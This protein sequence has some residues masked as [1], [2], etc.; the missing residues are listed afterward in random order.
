MKISI[1]DR[2][3]IKRFLGTFFVAIMLMIAIILVFDLSEK[4]GKF[5]ENKIPAKLVIFNYYFSLVPYYLNI[6]MS[7]FI[8]ISIIFFTSKMAGRS[9][10]IAM[11]SGGISFIRI[12]R[13]YFITAGILATLSFFLGNFI[14]PPAN[15]T[16][17]EFENKYIYYHPD[18]D[19]RNIHKQVHQGIFVYIKYYDKVNDIGHIFTLEK[20]Q[21]SKLISK[22]YADN[23]FWDEEN[24]L[25]HANNY[26][27]RT[28]NKF[29]DDFT[30][31]SSIDTT[32]FLTPDDIKENSINISTLNLIE[33]NDFID[34]QRLHGNENI[35]DF[36][37]EKHKRLALPFSAF[38]LAFIGVSMSARKKRGGTGIYLGIGITLSFAYILLSKLSDQWALNG[39]LT[40]FLAVWMPNFI[41]VFVSFLLYRFAPK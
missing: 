2:Y 5:M 41:F 18:Q 17:I 30:K 14:I 11:L 6:F 20:F 31:G 15:K 19:M 3:I 13:P 29:S 16:R 32:F 24:K 37:L 39:D 9:E 33:L 40:P 34:E 27:I 21:G 35:N 12:V 7:L 25:W 10:F 38:V 8:F 1:L 4:L 36:L 22:L 26:N 28:I 23:I